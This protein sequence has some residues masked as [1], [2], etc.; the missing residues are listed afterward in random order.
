MADPRGNVGTATDPLAALQDPVDVF[1]HPGQLLFMRILIE[2]IRGVFRSVLYRDRGNSQVLLTAPNGTVY[3]LRVSN[4][5]E[6]I[7]DEARSPD[8][9]AVRAI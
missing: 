6:L 1:K 2:A 9:G 5:M 8:T 7:I 3:R 4:A